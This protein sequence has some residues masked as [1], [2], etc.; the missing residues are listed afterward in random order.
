M[1]LWHLVFFHKKCNDEKINI[2]EGMS[3]NIF[4][5]VSI[6][7]CHKQFYDNSK[8]CHKLSTQDDDMIV[9][10]A[11]TCM[12][13]LVTC[14]LPWQYVSDKFNHNKSIFW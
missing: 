5:N 2:I 4:R 14:Q 6:N 10:V 7:E 9:D 3:L 12:T 1:T 13:W 11:V 8:K